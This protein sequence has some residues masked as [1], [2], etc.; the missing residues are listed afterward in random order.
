MQAGARFFFRQLFYLAL[1]SKSTNLL[2]EPSTSSAVVQSQKN[3]YIVYITVNVNVA[4]SLLRFRSLCLFVYFLPQDEFRRVQTA[5][6]EPIM[7][8]Q[9]P[10]HKLSSSTIKPCGPFKRLLCNSMLRSKRLRGSACI[11]F[12]IG[13]RNNR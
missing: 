10:S 4:L 9:R 13:T 5:S 7:T 3:K 2:K 8:T 1:H 11:R 12:L 6:N